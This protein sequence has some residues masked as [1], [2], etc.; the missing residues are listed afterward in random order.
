MTG[1][2]F[3]GISDH[4][5]RELAAY[6]VARVFAS[7]KDGGKIYSEVDG[8]TYRL[9]LEETSEADLTKAK[10][11]SPALRSLEEMQTHWARSDNAANN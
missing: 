5:Y 11:E 8:Q 1:R 6:F 4:D 3:D 2:I 7:L 9:I 10:K